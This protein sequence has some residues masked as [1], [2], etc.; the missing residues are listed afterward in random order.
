MNQTKYVG[1]DVHKASISIAVLDADGKL[2]SEAIIKPEAST[3]TDFFKGLT[4]AV[5]LTFEKGCHAQWLFETL[6]PLIAKL[7]VCD[8]KHNKLLLSGN[9]TDRLDAQKLA[10]LLRG[11]LLKGVYHSTLSSKAFKV[12]EKKATA[13]GE[14]RIGK[15]LKRSSVS[16][17]TTCGST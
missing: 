5:H 17:K 6:H 13:G 9:K 16:I 10:T 15:S 8:P 3:I 12:E 1:L 2:L 14:E 7:V 11:N 4:G